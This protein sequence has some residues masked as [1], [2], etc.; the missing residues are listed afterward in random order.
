MSFL[1]IHLDS[2][3]SVQRSISAFRS[4]VPLLACFGMLGLTASVYYFRPKRDLSN[5]E[6]VDSDVHARSIDWRMLRAEKIQLADNTPVRIP[7]F[8]VPLEDGEDKVTEF[9]L[10]PYSRTCVH[11]ATPPRNQIVHVQMATHLPVNA[12]IRHP[13]W[14]YGTLRSQSSKAGYQMMSTKIVPLEGEPQ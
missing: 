14:V 13:V 9:L 2:G 1:K 12:D 4:L 3:S 5:L 8:M 11:T 6:F 10:V 7:G